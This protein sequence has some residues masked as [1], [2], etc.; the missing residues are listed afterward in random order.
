M[1]GYQNYLTLNRRLDGRSRVPE[2][3]TWIFGTVY[4]LNMI[5]HNHK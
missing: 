2:F 4:K 5:G 1:E 3:G